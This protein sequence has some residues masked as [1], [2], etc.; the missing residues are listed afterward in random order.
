M[1]LRLSAFGEKLSAQTGILELMDDLGRSMAGLDTVHMLAAG[2]PAAIP[3]VQEVWRR[4]VQRL[5]EDADTLDSILVNYDSSKGQPAFIEALVGFLNTRYGWGITPANVAVTNGS[6]TAYFILL[7]MLAGR[8]PDGSHRKILLP[9]VPEY[10]GYADQGIEQG[11]FRA[12]RPRIEMLDAHAF[13][14]RIDFDTLTLADDVAAICVT[15]PTNPSGNVLT[16]GEV[17]RLSA[18]AADRGIPLLIDNAYGE[19]FPGIVFT[20]IHP[21]WNENIILSLSLSKI[22]LPGTRTGVLI[23]A[24][25]I[26]RTIVN[27][28]AVLSLASGNIGQTLM[29]PLLRDGS[30]VD[31]CRNAVRPF[32]RRKVKQA[33]EWV[34]RFFD[35]SLPYAV[36]RCEG[37]LFLWLWCR[38]LPIP[39]AELYERL[40]ARGVLVV[41]GHHFFYGLDAPWRHADECIRM[42]VTQSE[43]TV[44]EGL[45]GI[46]A[47]VAGAYR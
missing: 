31:L 33:Q 14:Y 23:A 19:P 39:A 41:P 7:N 16:D 32:Y 3:A 21:L 1:D 5:V 10:I 30:I 22:G 28:N 4:G 13:K 20:D 24:E 25:P 43:K 26:V 45:R 34:R 12:H 29:A 6:Q 17:A 36:H 27:I 37:A 9:L 38:D 35:D 2:N 8:M 46:A 40:K 11:L 15:R 47:E 44:R 42:N 18:L